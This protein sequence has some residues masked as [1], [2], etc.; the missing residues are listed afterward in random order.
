MEPNPSSDP[1]LASIALST[2]RLSPTGDSARS[3]FLIGSADDEIG[4]AVD[5]PFFLSKFLCDLPLRNLRND[6]LRDFF[7]DFL[8]DIGLSSAFAISWAFNV[9]F[10]VITA[11]CK[12]SKNHKSMSST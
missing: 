1:V 10:V 8:L 11:L 9:H 7:S 4:L 2:G 3:S 12:Q 5:P 6:S